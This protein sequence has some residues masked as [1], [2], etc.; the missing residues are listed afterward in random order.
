M[1]LRKKLFLLPLFSLTGC[2]VVAAQIGIPWS[3]SIAQI[4]A[5]PP[6][7]WA[8]YL[9]GTV[10]DTVPL[11][12]QQVYQ[13]QDKTGEIWVLTE[14]NVQVGDRLK[15]RGTVRFQP[16]EIEGQEQGEVYIEEQERL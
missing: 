12:N 8:V 2:S 1:T 9:E 3:S 15:I 7:N 16:A 13:L 4:Q 6:T 10:S 5:H 14:A 11:V